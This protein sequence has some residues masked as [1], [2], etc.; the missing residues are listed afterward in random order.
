MM[1]TALPSTMVLATVG[2]FS[3]SAALA[4][5]EITDLVALAKAS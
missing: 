4:R 3:A 2:L 1:S 5:A